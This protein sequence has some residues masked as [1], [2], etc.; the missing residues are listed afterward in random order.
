M[1][2]AIDPEL[3]GMLDYAKN[4]Q[5]GIIKK[6]PMTTTNSS[7]DVEPFYGYVE[8]TVNALRLIHAARQ[9]VIP[10][11]TR[12]L[13]DS[14]RRD[15]IKSGSVFVFS[16]EESGIKR[17]TDGLLWSPSRIV[18]NF[19]VYREINERAS[20]RGGHRRSYGLDDTQP[21]S[22]THRTSPSQSSIG[23]KPSS[24]NGTS[25]DHGTFKPNGLI[26]KTITVTI[27]GSDLHLISYY[28]AE[29]IRSGKLKKPSSRQDI[30]SL[31]MPPHLFRLTN[32]RVPPKVELGPDGKARL[33]TEPEDIDGV[34][35][36]KV[37][38]TTYHLP[39]SPN[40]PI[41]PTSP[42]ESPFGGNLYINHDTSYHRNSVGDRWSSS[43][44]VVRVASPARHDLPWPLSSGTSHSSHHRREGLLVPSPDSWSPPL[45][46]SR[47]DSPPSSS[48]MYGDRP[49]P[50]A[51][52]S[53]QNNPRESETLPSF[54]SRYSGGRSRDVGSHRVPWLLNQE[55]SGDRESRSSCRS[56]YSS[57]SSIPPTFTPDGYH[58]YSSAWPAPSDSS[59]LNVATPPPPPSFSNH[60]YATSFGN[61]QNYGNA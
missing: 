34:V 27:D 3:D 19:L 12:R 29:D 52:N 36:P 54:G 31:Y 6:V 42:T 46:S 7:S 30:M 45:Q 28:T 61:S 25:G 48:G 21:R 5:S 59:T 57:S 47:Y 58:T 11:I 16:V 18:G 49:R 39:H 50:R 40:S 4:L 41:S 2:H 60:G 1:S 35:E 20:S 44:D 53:Y 14:E 24:P 26:K 37:E 23:Y 10:R 13:N 15:M 22:L 8:T 9:G 17:W 56:S 43:G 32:F 51:I 38:E 33:V 55:S